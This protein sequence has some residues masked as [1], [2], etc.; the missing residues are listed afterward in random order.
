MYLIKV[1]PRAG[2]LI[3]ARLVPLQSRRFRLTRVSTADA[4]WMCDLLNALGT[5][6]GTHVQLNADDSMSLQR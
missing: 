2:R 5:S 3:E 6:F 4:K 1:D